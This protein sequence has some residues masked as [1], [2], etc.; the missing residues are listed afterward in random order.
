MAKKKNP[1]GLIIFIA[2]ALISVYF[3]PNSFQIESQTIIGWDRDINCNQGVQCQGTNCCVQFIEGTNIQEA[4]TSYKTNYRDQEDIDRLEN[5]IVVFEEQGY[6]GCSYKPYTVEKD[7]GSDYEP[8]GIAFCTECP[9]GLIKQYQTETWYDNYKGQNP[10]ETIT[11]ASCKEKE[12]GLSRE[13]DSGFSISEVLEEEK[14]TCGD[15]SEIITKNCVNFLWEETNN[16]CCTEEEN[17]I[18]TC[19]NGERVKTFEC[20]ESDWVRIAYCLED[21]P[22]QEVELTNNTQ[23]IVINNTKLIVNKTV[24]YVERDFDL[25][26]FYEINKT[27]IWIFGILLF[28]LFII[29]IARLNN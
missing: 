21:F 7:S 26:S 28:L 18:V 24:I 17:K 2:V 3:I 19:E 9:T 6:S 4:V 16:I 20:I 29:I 27:P 15:K 13:T 1:I 11:G 10:Q 8:K 23:T 22:E 25:N 5:A 14:E 12:C